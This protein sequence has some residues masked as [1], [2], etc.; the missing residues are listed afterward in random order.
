MSFQIT[1]C[2]DPVL[3]C[4]IERCPG[5]VTVIVQKGEMIERYCMNHFQ[6]WAERKLIV[7]PLQEI[8]NEEL[9]N[10]SPVTKLYPKD[11]NE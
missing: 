5:V 1:F 9:L 6:Q 8:I 10:P 7:E 4:S 2:H 3:A 11:K